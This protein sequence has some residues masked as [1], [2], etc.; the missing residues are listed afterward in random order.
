MTVLWVAV[1]A[2]FAS[3]QTPGCDSLSGAQ[4]RLAERIMNSEYLYECCDD[5]ISHCLTTEP[6][7]ALAVRLAENVCRRVSE[8]QD[9]QRIRRGLSRRARSMVGGGSTSVIKTEGVPSFGPSDAPVTVVIYA[10][11]RCPYCSQLIPALCETFS[12]DKKNERVRLVF[13]IFPIKGHEGSTTA[14]LGF[15]AAAEL[16]SFWPFMLHAYAHFDDYSPELQIEWAHAVGLDPGSFADL[17]AAPKTRETLV[18][19]KKEGLVNGVEETPTL[20][21][22]GRHWV[23]DLELAEILDAIAE[24]VERMEAHTEVRSEYPLEEAVSAIPT[25]GT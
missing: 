21:I 22:N 7:C 2:G 24:E 12:E 3:A 14:G 13:R 19:G 6:T 5:T 9:E 11:A 15:A 1:G 25:S 20:F 18:E 17:V 4:R 10:C 16:G 8:G 23:G